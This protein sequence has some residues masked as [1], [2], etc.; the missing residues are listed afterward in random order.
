[1]GKDPAS[2]GPV[3]LIP[4]LCTRTGLSEE[5]RSDFKIMKDVGTYTRQAP[6]QRIETLSTF[7]EKIQ[8]NVE[9]QEI[10]GGWNLEFEKSLLSF[11][12]RSLPPE[13]IHQKGSNYSY[14]QSEADWSRDMRGKKLISSVNLANYLLV[15]SNRDAGVAEEFVETLKKI[16][17][18]MGIMVND[19]YV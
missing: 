18:A 2:I 8:S 14:R 15:C 10:L 4:E 17:P 3:L 9:V 7:I 6:P 5:A 16:G 19:P 11:Q 12:G 1:M 13:T